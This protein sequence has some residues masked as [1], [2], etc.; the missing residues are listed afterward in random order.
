MVDG[1]TTIVNIDRAAVLET[2]ALSLSQITALKIEPTS[3]ERPELAMSQVTASEVRPKVPPRLVLAMSQ[4]T[5]LDLKPMSPEMST[6]IIP[7]I[8]TLDLSHKVR[9]APSLETSQAAAS[10]SKLASASTAEVLMPRPLDRNRSESDLAAAHTHSSGT[11]EASQS[12]AERTKGLLGSSDH[13]IVICDESTDE[14]TERGLPKHVDQLFV[15]VDRCEELQRDKQ[16]Y[17]RKS[18]GRMRSSTERKG[19][20]Q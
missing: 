11:D 17:P 15:D 5:T 12:S 16:P 6:M 20:V 1:P 3:Q 9:R 2:N 19:V 4:V 10:G 7:P 18:K 8:T 14:E 13:P